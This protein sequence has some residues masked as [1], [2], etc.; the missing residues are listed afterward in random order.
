M[1]KVQG[2]SRCKGHSRSEE[3]ERAS[4]WLCVEAALPDSCMIRYC[5]CSLTQEPAGRKAEDP[6]SCMHACLARSKHD[7]L[8]A[9]NIREPTLPV[10][11]CV[12][13]PAPLRPNRPQKMPVTRFRWLTSNQ[14]G[15]RVHGIRSRALGPVKTTEGPASCSEGAGLQVPVP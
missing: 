8:P 1:G 10:I 9:A 3:R 7:I 4:R 6:C 13:P 14:R 2:R 12:D 5:M 15:A 11:Q